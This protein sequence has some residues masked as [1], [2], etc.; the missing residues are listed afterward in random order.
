MGNMSVLT[1]VSATVRQSSARVACVTVQL[2]KLLVRGGLTVNVYGG[3][4][5][6][7]SFQSVYLPPPRFGQMHTTCVKVSDSTLCARKA[8]V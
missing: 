5:D 6:R 3:Q 2:A 7:H 4:L 1:V 8:L